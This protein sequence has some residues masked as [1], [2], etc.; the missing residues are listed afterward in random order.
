VITGQGLHDDA[1]CALL[2]IDVAATARTAAGDGAARTAWAV[3]TPLH[4]ESSPALFAVGGRER[5]VI[6][7]GAIEGPDKKPLS[8]PGFALCV[9]VA[10]GRE[11]WRYDVADPE[12]VPVVDAAGR[13][14]LGSGLNGN[15]VVALRSET[16]EELRAKS[17]PRLLWR[18]ET[19]H[20]ATGDLAL[21]R[22]ATVGDLLLLGA[23]NGDYIHSDPAPAGEVLVLDPENGNVRWSRPLPDTVLGRLCVARDLVIAPCRDGRAYALDLATGAVR[24]NARV[25]ESETVP[26]LAGVV[27]DGTYAFAVAADGT[28]AVLELNSGDLIERRKLAD[29]AKV[30]QNY[31]MAAPLLVEKTLYVPTET[32]GLHAFR[33]TW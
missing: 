9:D 29:P 15:A 14:Y 4:L 28:L 23:G 25:S 6:G 10:T 27:S 1:N 5:V 33:V 12:A 22:A 8:H 17:L 32:T 16:D 26:L 31:T 2:C 21:A 7:A 18:K 20:P 11:L 3:P 24:W 30:S 13:V 19:R